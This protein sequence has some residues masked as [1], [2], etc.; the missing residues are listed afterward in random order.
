MEIIYG[1]ENFPKSEDETCVAMGKFDGVHLGH[2]LILEELVRERKYSSVILTFNPSPDVFFNRGE[3]RNLCTFEEQIALFEEFKADYLLVLPFNEETAAI[4]ADEFIEL[5]KD[6]LNCGKIVGGRDISFGNGGFGDAEYLEKN[7]V[8]YDI[9]VN[10]LD[11]MIVDEKEVS[12]SNIRKY[13]EAGEIEKANAQ[14]GYEYSISG[15]VSEGFKRGRTMGFPT[16]NLKEDEGKVLPKVGVYFT[17]V[18]IEGETYN[19]ITNVGVR[20]TVSDGKIINAETYVSGELPEMYGRK[21]KVSFEK[22]LRNEVKFDS[23]E[24]LKAQIEKDK[25]EMDIFFSQF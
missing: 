8:D 16:L 24:D 3:Q 10:I 22:F 20:P 12:S 11:K 4:E 6:K 15:E 13:L 17:R 21:I 19:G 23:F 1:F 2:R 7:A 25:T 9:D 18:N 5:L 14:L